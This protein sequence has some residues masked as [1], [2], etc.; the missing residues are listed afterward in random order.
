MK[1]CNAQGNKTQG[2]SFFIVND[3]N[4]GIFF[5]ALNEKIKDHY[6]NCDGWKKIAKKDW[7]WVHGKEKQAN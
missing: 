1:S 2:V 7:A 5:V 4:I 6:E 3:N